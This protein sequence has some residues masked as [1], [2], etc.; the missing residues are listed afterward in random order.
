MTIF[1]KITLQRMVLA[2]CS[3]ML[4]TFAQAVVFQAEDYN[5]SYDTTAGNAGGVYRINDVDIQA[6][7]DA[8]GGYNIGWTAANEWLAFSNLSIATGGSYKIRLRV[9]AP[10]TGGV[11]SVDLNNGAIQLGSINI[12]NTGGW[13]SW[14]TV[15]ITTNIN[16]G[17]YSLGVFIKAAGWNF[18]WIEVV[19]NDVVTPT[20]V[21]TAYQHCSFGGW[22][23]VL[24]EGSYNQAALTAKG[25]INNDASSIKVNAGYEAVLFKDDNFSGE[26]VIV[27]SDDSCL[28]AKGFNDQVSSVIVRKA[29]VTPVAGYKSDKRGLAYGYHT[30][31]DLKAMQ[32]NVRWWYNWA[33]TPEN[34]VAG[35]Y[36]TYGFEFVPMAYRGSFDETRLR[37][38][39]KTHPDVKYILGFNEPNFVEQANMTPAQAAAAWPRLEAVARDFGLK[40]VAPAVNYSPGGVDIPGT[41]DDSS[42]W[43]YLDAFF[44]A[45]SNCRV[46][47]IAVHSYMKY[48][49]A[50]EWYIKEFE[51]YGKPIWVTEWA[52]WDD[53]GPANV[54][55][56]MDYLAETVR[57][58]EG[59]N[60]VFRYSW[61][62]GRGAGP[63]NFPYI[64]V[65]AGDGQLSPLGGLYT[66][67]PSTN[68]RYK[69]PVRIEA[70]GAHV[71]NGFRHEPTTD[72]TGGYVNVCWTNVGDS[73]EYKINVPSSVS[74]KLNF[75]VATTQSARRFNVLVDGQVL[76]TQTVNSTGGWQSWATVSSIATLPAGEHTLRIE[77]LTA[78]VNINWLEIVAN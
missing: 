76:F 35:N 17:T 54:N 19:K 7:T 45:C 77:A 64:D 27:A 47:Y 28:A 78:D 60:N 20:G 68:Y 42:P 71:N 36:Q 59:N 3:L 9:A 26:S 24:N 6:S 12:P 57:W 62:I 29:S 2:G 25:F 67:I 37:N 4:P 5:F 66:S 55:E 11:A 75:R 38:Y 33:E 18:N 52:S 65:L 22:T 31:N 61:F 56:Q 16:A 10:A 48:A 50:F 69:V 73:L 63:T 32:K 23:S 14:Q 8:G 21:V 41:N 53:G 74:Y 46:D 39:L 72:A 13:Q 1:T 40:I 44:A 34:A 43:A 51:R 58:L 15:E 30:P 70:E 49:S